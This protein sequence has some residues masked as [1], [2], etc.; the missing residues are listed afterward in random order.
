[1]VFRLSHVIHGTQTADRDLAV[2]PSQA[3]LADLLAFPLFFLGQP[4]RKLPW[5]KTN[6]VKPLRGN[7]RKMIYK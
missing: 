7:P 5:G 6:D 1:M 2:E 4:T 3:N